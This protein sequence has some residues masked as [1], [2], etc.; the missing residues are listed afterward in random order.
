MDKFSQNIEKIGVPP[1]KCQGIKTKLVNFIANN[2]QWQGEGKWI[3][4]FLG[5]G[6]M[7]FNLKPQRALVSDTNRHIIEFYKNIQNKNIDEVIVKEYLEDAHQKLKIGAQSYYLEIRDKFNKNPN[8]LDFL[9]LNRSCFNGLMR[10]NSKG[11]YNVPFGHK[12]ERFASAYITKIVHQISWIKKVMKDKEWVFQVDDW[13]KTFELAKEKDFVYIDPPYIGRHADYFNTWT[14]KDAIDLSKSARKLPCPFA[15]SMWV[16]N[17]YRTN[18][19]LN[20]YWSGLTVK[21]FNH[22]YHVG[23]TQNLRNEIQEGLVL[24][25]NI[26]PLDSNQKVN[27]SKTI[28]L[29]LF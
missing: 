6:V 22:F 24:S 20:K 19:H 7:L 10:F 21:T 28:A 29:E 16:K 27:N 4:P 18:E 13:N 12:P 9:F 1:I 25:H 5:S 23:A 3:E 8:S 17:K 11:Q 15:L 14:E 2:I 26:A